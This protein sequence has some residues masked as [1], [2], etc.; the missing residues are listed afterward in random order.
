MLHT[1]READ[2]IPRMISKLSQASLNGIVLI[3]SHNP[4]IISFCMAN[5]A[6][7]YYYNA[8]KLQ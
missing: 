8:I 3:Q 4:V 6:S 7:L 2:H 1:K 5:R